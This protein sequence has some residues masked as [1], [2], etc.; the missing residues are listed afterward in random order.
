MNFITDLPES[1]RY[2]SL[3]VVMDQFTKTVVITPCMKSI[4]S[5]SDEH[6]PTLESEEGIWEALGRHQTAL[7]KYRKCRLLPNMVG[8][9]SERLQATEGRLAALGSFH[10]HFTYLP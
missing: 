7:D 2:D 4:D 9:L 3:H 10:L 5:D 1:N 6:A 8:P